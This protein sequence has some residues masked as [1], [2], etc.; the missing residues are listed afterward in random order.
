MKRRAEIR[1]FIKDILASNGDNQPFSD[2]DSLFVGGRLQS[3][4]A[5]EVVL[6]LE[7]Q[8]GIDFSAIGFDREQID[9]VDAICA[10]IQ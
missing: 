6:F 7:K 10:L 1:A 9:S 3:I 8:F 5:V 4:D 2:Q